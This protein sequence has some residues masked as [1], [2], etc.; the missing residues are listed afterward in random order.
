MELVSG[1]EFLLYELAQVRQAPYKGTT[2][3]TEKRVW[4]MKRIAWIALASLFTPTFA[5]S[6][7]PPSFAFTAVWPMLESLRYGRQ[8]HSTQIFQSYFPPP[9]TLIANQT[10]IHEVNAT[11]IVTKVKQ[12]HKVWSGNA[13]HV[14]LCRTTSSCW[15]KRHRS[16][17]R[18]PRAH[19][20]ICPSFTP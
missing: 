13:L 20:R 14:C 2:G 16:H 6:K 12:S 18:A 5:H 7:R 17:V 15:V 1:C 19:W 4:V 3:R 11:D 10:L 9:Q 8:T